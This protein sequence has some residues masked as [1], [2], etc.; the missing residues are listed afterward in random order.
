MM[1]LVGTEIPLIKLSE[2]EHQ[3]EAVFF[4][5]LVR[6]ETGTD[7]HGNS[8]IKCTFRDKLVSYV[9]PLW[10]ANAYR[11]EAEHWREGEAYRLRA[12]GK[13]D[14]RF[15]FQLDIIEIRP[16]VEADAEDGYNFFDLV[17]SSNRD[18]HELFDRVVGYIDR[19]V[20]EPAL[21]RLVTAILEK[22]KAQF[23]R[24]PAAQFFHHNYTAGLLEHVWSVTRVAAFLADHYAAYY[25]E[26][27]PPL[28]KGVIVSA[29]ILHDIGKLFELAYHPV[30]SR[31][32]IQGKLIGHVL[33]G[34]DLVRDTARELG[35]VP[36]ETLLLLEHAILA[37]HGKEEFGAP[38]PPQ[39]IEALLVHYADDID[40]KMN[41]VARTRLRSSN[42][43]EPFTEKV[44]ALNNRQFYKGIPVPPVNGDDAMDA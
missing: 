38:R 10:H 37:H 2:L 7:K 1:S 19:Y 12:K 33:L 23:M 29:A 28:N 34:R 35:D 4:A 27:N 41:A 15:G 40:S 32:T 17:E 14:V 21:H 13:H 25:V 42:G 9:A 30:E 6:K 26:L 8:F 11:I 44:F 36:E 43:E 5:A 24:I 16:V 18:P 3:Q 22:H 20:E 39:T 31:Y